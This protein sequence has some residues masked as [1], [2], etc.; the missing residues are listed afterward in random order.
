M[1]SQLPLK[2]K[3]AYATSILDNSGTL[4]DLQGQVDRLVVKWKKQQGGASGWWWRLCWVAPPVGMAAGALCLAV[5]AWRWRNRVR[6]G[7]KRVSKGEGER[8][9][10]EERRTNERRRQ[11]DDV[12]E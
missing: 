12:Y 8:V 4:A 7:E 9:E 1:A 6:P 2:H 11:I 5:R 3:T 10:M